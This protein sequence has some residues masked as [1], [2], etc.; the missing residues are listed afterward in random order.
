MRKD[1]PKCWVVGRQNTI[2]Q[3][4]I[5]YGNLTMVSNRSLIPITTCLWM[6]PINLIWLI[7]IYIL[8]TC[9]GIKV[10]MFG[11]RIVALINGYKEFS[12]ALS[13]LTKQDIIWSWFSFNFVMLKIWRI[14][15]KISPVFF[16]GK[17]TKYF[18]KKYWIC[19]E[20]Q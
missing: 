9:I 11:I 20:I 7:Y 15:S 17:T 13:I 6:H 18:S 10:F 1:L 16:V 8:S 5:Q 14:F 2:W 4:Q 19:S 12:L 3:N